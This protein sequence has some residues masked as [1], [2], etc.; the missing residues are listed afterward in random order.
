MGDIQ[1]ASE[2]RDLYINISLKPQNTVY[3]RINSIF[4]ELDSKINTAATL[5]LMDGVK[6]QLDIILQDGEVTG[7]ERQSLLAYLTETEAK[8][9]KQAEDKLKAIQAEAKYKLNTGEIDLPTADQMLIDAQTEYDTS[10]GVIEGLIAEAKAEANITDWTASTISADDRQKMTDAINKEIAA[11]DALLVSGQRAGS[12][13]FR[14]VIT[15][16][17]RA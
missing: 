15:G 2:S 8:L 9:K 4:A 16:A 3:D 1:A 6:A 14:G 10:I 5:A 11:G 17:S 12:G 7:P 13:A